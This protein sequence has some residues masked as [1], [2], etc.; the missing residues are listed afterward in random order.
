MVV[1]A[2]SLL[3]ALHFVG[4]AMVEFKGGRVLEINPRVWGSYPLTEAAGSRFAEDYIRAASGTVFA[5]PDAAYRRGQRMRFVLNDTLSVLAHLKKGHLRV[6]ASGLADLFSRKGG[7]V[8]LPRPTS[9]LA[10]S[11]PNPSERNARMTQFKLDLHIHTERSPDSRM[12]L[13]Q[14]AAAAKQ[15]GVDALAVCDHNRCASGDVFRASR[16]RRRAPDP[17]AWSTP[18]SAATCSGFFAASLHLPGRGNRARPL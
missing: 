10:L 16:A 15:R 2:V 4:I 14:A 5:Q 6:A 8:P 12:T 11:A 3:Q 9:L 7:A 18:P 13:T 17:P 1:Q